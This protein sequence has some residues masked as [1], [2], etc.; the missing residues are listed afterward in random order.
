MKIT[1]DLVIM[2]IILIYITA[3]NIRDKKSVKPQLFKVCSV[4]VDSEMSA[5]AVE[6]IFNVI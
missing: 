4:N 2:N 1:T 3:V 6:Q 5:V